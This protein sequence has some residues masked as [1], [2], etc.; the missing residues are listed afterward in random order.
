MC[1]SGTSL[2]LLCFVQLIPWIVVVYIFS[3]L[4]GGKSFVGFVQV[5]KKSNWN[6]AGTA[7]LSSHTCQTWRSLFRKAQFQHIFFCLQ[8]AKGRQDSQEGLSVKTDWKQTRLFK[9]LSWPQEYVLQCH[10]KTLVTPEREWLAFAFQGNR[11][12]CLC[13]VA[14]D[15]P[16]ESSP[17]REYLYTFFR[18]YYTSALLST[19][20][21]PVVVSRVVRLWNE[22]Q[23]QEL[24]SQIIYDSVSNFP[25]RSVH[26]VAIS[27]RRKKNLMTPVE[28]A[29]SK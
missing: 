18:K 7:M 15:V 12:D 9:S 20:V 3:I 21:R 27:A 5:L 8:N 19:Y 14:S 11:Y 28:T 10:S 24:T 13:C 26:C 2:F 6:K 23:A 16:Q 17:Y 1:F 22:I 25:F 4:R 29:L